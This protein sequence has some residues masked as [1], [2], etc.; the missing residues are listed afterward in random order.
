MRFWRDG[1]ASGSGRDLN[2]G[3]PYGQVRVLVVGD[4]GQSSDLRTRILP[5]M[6]HVRTL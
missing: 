5:K 4:S 1:G 6:G 3:M 2:G